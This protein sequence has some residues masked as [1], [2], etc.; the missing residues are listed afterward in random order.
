MDPSEMEQV[1]GRLLARMEAFISLLCLRDCSPIVFSVVQH[2]FICLFGN[3][4]LF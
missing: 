1:M 2:I 4:K 3:S